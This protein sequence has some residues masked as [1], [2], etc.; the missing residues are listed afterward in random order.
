MGTSP[1]LDTPMPS[2]ACIIS[3]STCKPFV[4]SNLRELLGLMIQDIAQNA[5][6]MEGT[7]QSVVSSVLGKG[8]VELIAVGPTP[9]TPLVQRALHGAGVTFTLAQ[10]QKVFQNLENARGGSDLVAVVGMSGRFP[11]GNSISEFWETLKNGVDTH[12]Q[13]R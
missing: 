6:H 10:N 13:V 1:L 8:D 12:Q 9:H 11:K 5:L 4:A 2:K 3:S 7:I